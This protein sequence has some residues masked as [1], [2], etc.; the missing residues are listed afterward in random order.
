MF[1]LLLFLYS[2]YSLF[3]SSPE[4]QESSGGLCYRNYYKSEHVLPEPLERAIETLKL[5]DQDAISLSKILSG[6]KQLIK[7]DSLLTAFLSSGVFDSCCDPYEPAEELEET[8]KAQRKET[9]VYLVGRLKLSQNYNSTIIHLERDWTSNCNNQSEVILLNTKG[10]K[11]LSMVRV[12]MQD[13][14]STIEGYTTIGKG[15][16]F[17]YEDRPYYEDIDISREALI[18][19]KAQKEL[20]EL[21]MN[22]ADFRV[23]KYGFVEVIKKGKI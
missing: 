17:S 18:A 16:V 11:I 19:S 7:N 12:T 15:N 9:E 22:Y 8:R 20:L 3:L 10:P 14:G 21:T 23:N 13:F 5:Y 2:Q 6:E 4:V 1:L